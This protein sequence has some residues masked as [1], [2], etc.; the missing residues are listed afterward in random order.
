MVTQDSRTPEDYEAEYQVQHALPDDPPSGSG[1]PVADRIPARVRT[2]VYVVAVALG[3]AGV[4]AV[5][6][7]GAWWPQYVD[8]VSATAGAVTSAMTFICGGLGVVYRP[9]RAD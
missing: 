6:I 1:S 5:G 2:A 4:L 8:R 9:T 3:A 7:V